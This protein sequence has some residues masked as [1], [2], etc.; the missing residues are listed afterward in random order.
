MSTTNQDK[1]FL[2]NQKR[3]SFCHN[4]E[5]LVCL[6]CQ[7]SKEHKV[8][9]CCP[10][11]E[12]AEQK[13]TEISACLES[14]KKKLKVLMNTKEQWEEIK[15][16]IQTQ[17]C[18][19]DTGIKEEFKKLHQFLK[20]EENT[21]L[22]ALKQEEETKTQI[23]CKK[24]EN[25]EEQINTL[26]STI[27]DIETALK[28]QDIQLLQDYKKTK[29]R[30]QCSIGEPEVI[31]DILINSAKHL[32]SLSF[33]IWKKMEDIVRCVPV[34]LDPNTAQFNLE[35]SEEL[36]CVQY[37]SKKL[38]PNNTERLINRISVLG[39]T[40]FTSGKHSW[41]VDVGQGKDWYI[42]VAL[43]SIQRKNTIFLSPAEGFWVIGL[44]NGDSLWA[45]T[46]PRSK[47]PMKE[48]PNRITVELD[49]E[50]GKVIF[51][52]AADSTKIHTFKDKFTEKV[53]PYFSPG[54]CKDVQNASPL[55]ICPQIIKVKVE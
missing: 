9:V 2:H 28:A 39:A 1:C 16:Y 8:H 12:A 27:S 11:E 48:K 15:T 4:D 42:G 37:S 30:L 19:T 54:L 41:T 5:V 21:R 20:E 24:L 13:K 52:N 45:Q 7:Q 26:S 17:A 50:R 43:D 49:Y 34:V 47:L 55:T 36:S 53:F 25:I 31:R 38:L 33:Q 51:I 35:L 46:T 14:L 29:K 44:S 6:I 23:M 3:N 40:G 10:V 32:G 18:E 22:Q